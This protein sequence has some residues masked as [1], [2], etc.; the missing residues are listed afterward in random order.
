[1]ARAIHKLFKG[2]NAFGNVLVVGKLPYGP[3]GGTC[4]IFVDGKVVLKG[5][6]TTFPGIENLSDDALIAL[7]NYFGEPLGY[8][9]LKRVYKQTGFDETVLISLMACDVTMKKNTD[10]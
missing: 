6:A 5:K 1:M 2:N 9:N 10:I 7:L 8:Y 4:G 3:R